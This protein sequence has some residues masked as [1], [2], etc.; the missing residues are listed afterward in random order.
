M[1]NLIYKTQS[2]CPECL[3]IV[4]AEVY[5][6]D[7]RVMIKK[8]CS[9][10]GEFNDVYWEDA[11]FFKKAMKF[12]S[13]GKKVE[14]IAEYRDCPFSCGI[15]DNHKTHPT[16]LNIAITNRCDFA[17]WYCFFYAERSGYVFEP[18]IDQIRNM[19]RVA[20]TLKPIGCNGV[21]LT[22]GEPALREDLIEII[23]AVKNEGIKHVQ[24]NTN[25]IRLAY[26]SN[27]AY[28]V[29]KAGVD[30]VYLSFDGLDERTNPKNI[31]EIPKIFE[32]CRNSELDLVLVPTIIKGIN[33]HQLGDMIRF[34]AR[35]IDLVR[36]ISIQPV[37]FVGKMSNKDLKKYRITIPGCI[38]AIEEQTNGE[39]SCEDF[40][41]MSSSLAITSFVE[42]LTG[43]PQYTFT[44]HFACGVVTTI[45]RDGERLIPI[46]RFIDAEG[47][48][49]Y[50]LERAE[51]IKKSKFKK[52][53]IFKSFWDLRRF[54][55]LSK[56]PK[57][58]DVSKLLFK[59]LVEH[60]YF[61]LY[62]WHRK[63]ILLAMMHF[64]DLYNY[65]LARVQR[66]IIHY[67]TPDGRIIPFCTYNVLPEIYRDKIQREFGVPLEEWRK[68]HGL[69]EK[70]LK[71]LSK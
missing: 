36:S 62:E 50:M 63:S 66:C 13:D 31:R 49:E 12:A 20:K 3:K 64:Q 7:N 35:N 2:L 16:L 55:D 45:F 53:R 60:S 5:E 67:G 25:G 38:K 44:P 43:V 26:D 59:V 34:A 52:V 56:A 68:Q 61:A 47:L 29:K 71:I 65:D 8:S 33:E 39:I 11:T 19:V 48:L 22:G 18:S 10:H 37:S 21:Q 30:V 69:E 41:P 57:S 9:E 6:E 4:E 70:T 27:F 17:C 40:Y 46:T 42:A 23:R 28:E 58:F 54:F 24:L 51:V 15:C 1:T 32:N 14:P